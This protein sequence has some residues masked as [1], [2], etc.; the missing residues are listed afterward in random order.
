MSIGEEKNIKFLMDTD[1][2]V[3]EPID[4][5][6]KKYVLLG[7]FKK[8]DELLNQN[9]I[10]PTFIELSLHLASL[11]TLLKEN[12]ILYTDKVFHS[13]DDEVLVKDL[14]AKQLPVLSAPE[15]KEIDEIVKFSTTK[16]F[17]Y[18]N[19]VKSYWSFIYETISISVKKNKRFMKNG[20][21]YMIYGDKKTGKVYV[22]EY[23]F[24][25]LT[26]EIDEY[27]TDL[28]L[29]YNGNKKEFTLNQI[30]Q[31]FS[32]FN[33]KQKKYSPVFEVKSTDNYPF[34]ETLV[35][36]FKRKLISYVFQ[37]T[38]IESIK[39]YDN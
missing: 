20:I 2:L 18:F 23:V 16:F 22:W 1:W 17:D 38:R 21:G 25:K 29:I 3:Q 9:K 32:T 14:L 12:V 30:I 15:I 26:P 5:E 24:S 31:E 11:Q 34:E 39:K 7:Y 4:F 6:H 36:L 27:H 37:S 13:Y 8:I 28:T 10:Y 33:E 19:I 35:P